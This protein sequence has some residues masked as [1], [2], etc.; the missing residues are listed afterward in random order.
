MWKGRE[1]RAAAASNL[2]ELAEQRQDGGNIKREQEETPD[3]NTD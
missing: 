2:D 3:D 1:G